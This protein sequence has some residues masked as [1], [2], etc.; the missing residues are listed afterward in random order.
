MSQVRMPDG[1]VVGFPDDMP[2]EQI[3]SLIATKFP[4]T[5][6][7]PKP[8]VPAEP[9]TAPKADRLPEERGVF[10]RIDDAVRG[11]ADM[12]T[13]GFADELSAWLGSKT[14]VGGEA[15]N[16][17]ANLEAQRQRDSEDGVERLGGQLAGALLTPGGLAKTIPGT[18]AHGAA[19]GGLYGF[20]SGEGGLGDRAESAAIGGALGG[21]AGG[22]LRGVTNALGNRAAAKTIPSN[23][24][25][26]RL[27]NAAYN[28]ADMAGVIIKPEGMQRLA[29][30][31]VDDLVD[32]GYDPVLQPG[33]KAVLDRL[34]DLGNKNVTLK[35]L[36]VVRKVAGNAAKIRDNP[37]QQALA[38]KI[39]G[40]IDDYI[41]NL[42]DSDV[43]TGNPQIG[44]NALRE[45]RELWSRL[46]KSEMVDT[47]ALKAERRAASTGSGANADNA[48][49]QNV[50]GLLDNPRTARGMTAAERGA[51]ERVVRGTPTQNALRLA[52]KFAPTGVVSG[53]L[54]GGAGV[55][56]AGPAGL[57]LPLVG[58]VAKSAAD[59]MTV[60]NAERLS[61]IMRSGGRT[62]KDLGDLARGGQISIPQV[63]RLS[64][65]A[66][67]IGIPLSE[68][69][70]MLKERVATEVQR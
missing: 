34:S 67:R 21:A 53:V 51:A 7:A 5:S 31:M 16:Y 48:L 17:D 65:F 26:R 38:S 42:P 8:A 57:A 11:A 23:E 22:A 41:D 12:A 6:G 20:G 54:S 50:R 28:K 58:A 30:G 27:A 64:K 29:T 13:F 61:Q 1:T 52:G 68:I 33:V 39:I 18:V 62:A 14:G 59:R 46:R 45:A 10:R 37:S 24:E 9:Q 44:S 63:Q 36:D 66:S 15:G 19:A 47:A 69:A 40:R 49:R 2:P 55:G 4:D 43:L 32:F 60:K 3:K 56:L 35:G 70:A 25:L